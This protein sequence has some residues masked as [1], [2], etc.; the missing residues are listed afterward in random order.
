MP[1]RHIEGMIPYDQVDFVPGVQGWFNV[2][3]QLM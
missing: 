3:D 1:N 2:Q